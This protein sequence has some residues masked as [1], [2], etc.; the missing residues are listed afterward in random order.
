M[1]NPMSC[2]CELASV[3]ALLV[4][5]TLCLAVNK[6]FAAQESTL[7]KVENFQQGVD[8]NGIPVGWSLY[9]GTGNDQYIRLVEME[10][11]SNA[12]VIEDGDANTEMGLVRTFPIEPGEVYEASVEVKA[13]E[14][15]SSYGAYLQLR[16][17]PSDRYVQTG[18][19]AVS[20]DRF[21]TVSVKGV[22]PSDTEKA[23][24]YMYTHR[25]PTPKVML[26]NFQLVSGVSPPPPSPQEVVPPVYEKLKNLNVDTILVS[27]GGADVTIIAPASSVYREQAERIQKHIEKLTDVRVAIETDE[28]AAGSV[29]VTGNL[30]VLG[31]RSTSKTIGELYNLYYTL[32]DLRYPGQD[33]YIVR[34]LHNPF[35][36]GKNVVF[37][38]GSDSPGVE[39]ATEAFIQRLD[40][41]G[42]ADGNLSIGRLADI[43]LG[44]EISVP[45][46]LTKFE[47]WEASA[48]Y[49]STGYFGW[50]SISKRMA[51]YY[52]TG[53][54]F[55]AREVIRLAFPD[56]KAMQEISE[57]DGERIENKDE[58]LSGPYH[59]NAH[60]MILFWD[61]IEES[62]VFSD[63]E[64]LR[65]TNA[66]SRQL[67]HRKGEGV[68]GLTSV[69]AAVGSRHGQWSSV[70]LY[71][72]GRYF[73]KDYPD[74][75][76]QQCMDGAKLHFK[77]LHKH[78]WVS[79]EN[80]NLFWYNTA[81]A[82]IFTYLLLTG[83]REPVENGVLG[84][85][86][87]A[88]EMIISGRE[89]DWALRSASI[90]YLHKAAY[91][92]QDG[93]YILYRD[94]TD[95]DMN[96]FRLG[97]SFWPEEN[98]VSRSPDDLVGKWSINHLPR[99]MWQARNSG[100]KLEESFMFGSFR[101][102]ADASGDFLLID[103]FNGAS[104]NPYHTFPILELRLNGYTL[105]KGYRNQLLT[106]AD[107][108]VEP[109]IAMNAALKRSDVIGETAIAIGEVPDATYCAWRRTIV[110][111][112]GSYTLVV[113][114]I[115]PRIDTEN[116]E[117]E[118]KWETE[119][120]AQA[121]DDGHIEFSA[122]MEAP[123]R[124]TDSG[125]Q[126]W[127]SDI[128]STGI[129]GR[130]ATMKWVGP[131]RKGKHRI[132]FSLLGMQPGADKVEMG[133]ISLADNAAVLALPSPALAVSGEFQGISAELAVATQDHLYGNGIRR[134]N[135]GGSPIGSALLSATHPVDVDWNFQTGSLV[136]VA[137]EATEIHLSDNVI[138][139][140]PGRHNLE[141]VGLIPDV[142]GSREFYLSDLLAE[143]R[144]KR[145]REIAAAQKETRPTASAM[146]TAMVADIGGEVIDLTT[147]TIDGKNLICAAEGRTVHLISPDGKETRTLEADGPIRMV[148]WWPEHEL[149]L[150][151]CADE[152]VIAFDKSGERVWT[153]TSEMDPAVFRAAKTYWFKSARGH[154]GIHGLYTG[155]FLD[156]KSQAF[157]GSAC[158]LE[159]LDENGN[160]IKRMPQFWGKVSHFAMIDG[161]DGSLNLLASRKYNGN[162]TVAII[163]NKTMNPRQ[164][165]FNSVPPGATYVPG[166]SSMNRHH[167]FYE[168]IDGD[169]VK[170]VISEI[171][172]T[173]NRVTV[174]QADG[175]AL[176]DA[177]FGP[178]D[179]I[180]ARN[181]RDLDIADLNGDGKK[182]ILAATSSGL[183]VVL[184]NQCRK[185]WTK[186]L[187][188][189][190]TVM[191][192]VTP[193][194]SAGPW[195]IIGCEDGAVV[196]LDGKGELIRSDKVNGR[197]TC[198]DEFGVST[199]GSMVLV[200]TDKGEVKAFKLE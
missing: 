52:M 77:P 122:S 1:N 90:G 144:N 127:N 178:G 8:E 40:E 124:R 55:H 194:S 199:I 19:T 165:G 159:I 51:M 73:Q 89:P 81:I 98:L 2:S 132:F 16:F 117:V 177:S 18:L 66:F 64:R 53:D 14:G 174:W 54:E 152:Q 136:I 155:V 106:R 111:R 161:P 29:P 47:M 88:Q 188:S 185:L 22:A 141:N 63:E 156:G 46:D 167:I 180:P 146:K 196:V 82:P 34:T 94:R 9:G 182:E 190:A 139:L 75:I 187:A 26:R 96:T 149:L 195:V 23:T 154:E 61:L 68:Y 189:A 50:N 108:L 42:F 65:V 171:N 170:E 173:W 28:S 24:I 58:P 70:S 12:V 6:G 7:V 10:G 164:R 69:P 192:C 56:E 160:L 186:R 121:F 100:L 48:G 129:S 62:P 91:L 35:G 148:R 60:M 147:L 17:L 59:Y 32:L 3:A 79:G 41:A 44:K 11:S 95:V 112:I 4:L 104:R 105:L 21:E 130:V 84:Q 85:L 72:L 158:T 30:I 103:G 31:N 37:V 13:V 176:Y 119:R 78:A 162:N 114:D 157:V 123:D 140:E 27:N 107:G 71:C 15:A 169:G 175:K 113:D 133:C 151:G 80:D 143:G 126:I 101:S 172:G 145:S 115:I 5:L 20:T 131:V 134:V 76:W 93:R 193:K 168:D 86:L 197:P 83:D 36:N 87:K 135:I 163:N 45:T 102:A 191:K 142:L 39:A 150:V 67:N 97:Q 120:S 99:P 137:R 25:G 116:M 49:G 38:G 33:G 110:H 200:A 183:I 138:H 198:I 125:A 179:R 153:F 118:I 74:P 181:M 128:M 92:M 57:I 166:W 109:H 43:R 184:D